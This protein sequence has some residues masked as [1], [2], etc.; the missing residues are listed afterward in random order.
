MVGTNGTLEIFFAESNN[1]VANVNQRL[2][3]VRGPVRNEHNPTEPILRVY[4]DWAN[5]KV[6]SDE[7]QHQEVYY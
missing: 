1:G 6:V 3:G 5:I 4:L 7:R 2:L